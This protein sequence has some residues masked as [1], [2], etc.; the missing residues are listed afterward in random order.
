MEDAGKK[1]LQGVDTVSARV[2]CKLASLQG[3]L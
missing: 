1:R 3:L 2:V